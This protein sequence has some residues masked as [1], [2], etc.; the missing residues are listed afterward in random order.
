MKQKHFLLGEVARLVGVKAYQ[1]S[2][3]LETGHIDEPSGERINNKRIFSQDDIARVR[4]Y[5]KGK[6]KGVS[7]DK[8][9]Q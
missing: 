1:L 7:H 5:F 8:S 2:Y 3:A 4:E 6:R 9:V